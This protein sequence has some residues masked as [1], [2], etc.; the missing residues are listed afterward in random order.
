MEVVWVQIQTVRVPEYRLSGLPFK[1]WVPIET[2][3]VSIA[4]VRVNI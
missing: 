2:V 3:R 1:F 4:T